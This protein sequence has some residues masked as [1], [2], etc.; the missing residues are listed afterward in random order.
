[1]V[2]FIVYVIVRVSLSRHRNLRRKYLNESHNPYL[3]VCCTLPNTQF[4]AERSRRY[5]VCDIRQSLRVHFFLMRGR[6]VI[7]VRIVT[8]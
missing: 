6:N 5:F 4:N 2:G 7:R 1:M 8:G 3:L